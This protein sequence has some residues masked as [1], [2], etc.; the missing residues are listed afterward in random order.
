MLLGGLYFRKPLLQVVLD[1]VFELT[2]EGWRKLTFRWALFFFALAALN[3]IVWRT[4]TTDFW[5]SFK[6]LRHHAAHHRVRARPDAAADALRREQEGSARASLSTTGARPFS[7]ISTILRVT[8]GSGAHATSVH[9]SSSPGRHDRFLRGEAVAFDRL[10]RLLDP[11][12]GVDR[13]AQHGEFEPALVAHHAAEHVAR[14]NADAD[15][16][17]RV[18]AA[19]GVPALDQVEQGAAAGK[20]PRGIVGP[21]PP[22][23]R[24]G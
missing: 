4:Q 2:D 3:E 6:V 19:L 1:S 18:E 9:R 7:P 17:R 20:R 15:A 24:T 13:L 14:V 11:R 10:G 22:A 21:V 16:H 12:R 5:V 8:P 23:R